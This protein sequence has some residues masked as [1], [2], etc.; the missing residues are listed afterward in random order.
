MTL[1][2]R[3]PALGLFVDRDH[4][5][6]YDRVLQVMRTR[7]LSPRTIETY[8]GWIRRFIAFHGGRHPRRLTVDDVNAFL[9][10]LAENR[11]VSAA[12]QNQALAA[13]LFLYKE[14][15]EQPFGRLEGIVRAQRPA[16]RPVVLTVEEALHVLSHIEGV[17]AL[18]CKIQYG[19][20]LRVNEVLELRVKD[21]DFG[22]GEIVVRRGK[23]GNDR[24]APLP[25]VL[26]EALKA[27]LR[28]VKEQ[29]LRDLDSGR[30]RAPMPDALARK[31]PNADREWAW[32]WV[33]PA[34]SHY[35]DNQTGA[36]HR[37]H[38]HYSVVQKA[39]KMAVTRSGIPKKITTHTFRHSFATH[40]LEAHYDIRTI[41]EL[42]GHV[43]VKT[44]MKYTHVLNRGGLGV[45]SPLDAALDRYVAP[46]GLPGSL[47]ATDL[48]PTRGPP[49]IGVRRT[50]LGVTMDVMQVT[51]SRR[52]VSTKE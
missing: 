32:Q 2:A 29:H 20:G 51:S 27:H 16:T 41:Q 46:E 44:T 40:L 52:V 1:A 4:P 11:R 47:A 17:P 39:L 45:T 48:E 33:F 9:S 10:D 3:R 24:V 7:H 23:G 34:S 18:V 15:L 31:Y 19:S 43:S 35:R 38:L 42:L 26:H 5:R 37:Y 6:L 8:I 25:Q 14:V 49:R 13:V 36:E 12:T 22:R 28:W 50:A 21:V 30:G